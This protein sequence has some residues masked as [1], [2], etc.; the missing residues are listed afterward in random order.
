MGLQDFISRRNFLIPHLPLKSQR[1]KYPV[2][3]AMETPL[4]NTEVATADSSL[5]AEG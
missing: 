3:A 1:Q 4:F 5:T 2:S